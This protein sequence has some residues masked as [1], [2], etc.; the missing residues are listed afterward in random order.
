MLECVRPNGTQYTNHILR[1][2]FPSRVTNCNMPRPSTSLTQI[3]T[4]F[5]LDTL[6]NILNI[7]HLTNTVYI[8]LKVYSF[9]ETL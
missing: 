6:G 3:I 2:T 8:H 7:S 5:N 1:I 4:T 9:E